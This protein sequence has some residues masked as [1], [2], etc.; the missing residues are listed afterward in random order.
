MANLHILGDTE[1]DETSI[2]LSGLISK[3]NSLENFK[4]R[5]DNK[6]YYTGDGKPGWYKVLN[7]GASG[8]YGNKNGIL[9]IYTTA[10]G[11]DYV[12]GIVQFTYYNNWNI[13]FFKV[14]GNISVNNLKLVKNS[15]NELSLYFRTT[16]WY[17]P[18]QVKILTGAFNTNPVLWDGLFNGCGYIGNDLPSGEQYSCVSM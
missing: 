6:N 15:N 5:Y 7:I 12:G 17:S 1:I 9:Y 4:Y 10:S 14:C 13:S 16:T 11:G 2:T 3:I 8:G 18:V